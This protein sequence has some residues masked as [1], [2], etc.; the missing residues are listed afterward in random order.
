MKHEE[1]NRRISRLENEI[2]ELN[3]KLSA[4][5]PSED[6][7]KRRDEQF[8]AFYDDCIKIARRT[9]ANILQEKFLP[10]ALSE[11]Y[12]ITVKSAGEEGNKRYFIAS[13]PDKDQEWECNRPSFI[14]SSD[15][16][17]ITIREDGKVTP[18][19]HQHSEALTEFAIDYLNNN[20]KQGLMKRIGRCMG[21]L[22]VAAE[23]EA[24]ASGADKD[25][26]VREA[27]LRDFDNPPFKKVPAYWFHPGLTYLK[28]RI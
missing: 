3:K 28:V 10:T 15:D 14:V 26:V 17:N 16:W 21:Y 8:T 18:A 9:F 24:L 13:A 12:S 19:S 1:M 27:L 25:A 11:K 2:A 20:K 5:M 22:Q 23:I 6:A 7:K 4:L